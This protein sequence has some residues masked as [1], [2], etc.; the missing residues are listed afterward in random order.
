MSLE[1]SST[2]EFTGDSLC[3]KVLS[4]E[5]KKKFDDSWDLI[6]GKPSDEDWDDEQESR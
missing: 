3:T 4:G 6:F 1:K 2:N 5:C